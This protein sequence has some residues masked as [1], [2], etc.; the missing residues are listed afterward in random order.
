MA[1]EDS[2]LDAFGAGEDMPGGNAEDDGVEDMKPKE[3]ALQD[4]F[5]AGE[6]GDMAAAAEAFQ[7]AYDIC[8]AKSAAAQ[9]DSKEEAAEEEY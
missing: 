4:F 8:K 3:R 2:L 7:R 6:S 5:D 9:P 1:T